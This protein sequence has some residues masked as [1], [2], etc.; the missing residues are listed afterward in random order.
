MRIES[1]TAPRGFRGQRRYNAYLRAHPGPGP[2]VFC[3]L[4]ADTTVAEGEH[5]WV[6]PNAFP[7]RFWDGQHVDEHLLL[8]PKRHAI[9]RAE[10]T[11][12]ERAEYAELIAHYEEAG[13]S[14]W[15]RS[16]SNTAKSIPHQH[17]H[18]MRLTG[19]QL[20]VMFWL[21]RPL[22]VLAR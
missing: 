21:R 16:P 9:L 6:A 5:F 12:A 11:T 3:A 1:G 18:L 13:Y 4:D 19:R 8:V 7:Y 22:V 15:S 20:R 17:T 2:C 14:L 10:F